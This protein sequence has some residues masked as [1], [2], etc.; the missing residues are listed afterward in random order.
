METQIVSVDG[1]SKYLDKLIDMA[2]A[3]GPKVLLAVIVLIVGLF[4]I[5]KLSGVLSKILKRRQTDVTLTSF[6][7]NLISM[8]LKVLLIISVAQMVGIETTSFVAVMAAASLAIGM[9]LQGSLGNFAGGAL[10]LF[11]R[12]YKIGDLVEAQG[13]VG[14]VKEIQLF[15]THII[16]PTNRLVIIP[17]GPMSNG[18]IVNHSAEGRVRV[19]IK[20]AIAG[21]EDIDKARTEVLKVLNANDLILKTPAPSVNVS[22]LG[23]NFI[24]FD[25][26]SYCDP[27]NYWAVFYGTQEQIKKAFVMASVKGPQPLRIIQQG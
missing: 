3:Y 15:T 27:G 10:I 26:L 20:I 21:D 13:H 4:I 9:A 5:N 14:H 18:S 19:D 22:A 1:A 2:I 8:A 11:F 12:P 25:V 24:H 23:D 6:L 17:N 16:T 7:V